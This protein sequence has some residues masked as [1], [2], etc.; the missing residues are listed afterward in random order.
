[1][2]KTKRLKTLFHTLI[3]IDMT[4]IQ[5]SVGLINNHVFSVN[6]NDFSKEKKKQQQWNLPFIIINQNYELVVEVCGKWKNRIPFFCYHTNPGNCFCCLPHVCCCLSI[7]TDY[8]CST[9]NRH[10]HFTVLIV[11]DGSWHAVHMHV[12]HS[13]NICV[14]FDNNCLRN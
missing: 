1:M 2:S 8:I 12:T 13:H 14:D 6:C 7:L 9:L 5:N 4:I 10:H 11:F 3:T